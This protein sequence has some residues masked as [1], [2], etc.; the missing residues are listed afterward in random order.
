MG[1]AVKFT[2]AYLQTLSTQALFKLADQYGL[3]LSDDLARHLLIGELLELEDELMKDEGVP[4]VSPADIQQKN[5]VCSYNMTE[6]RA[7]LKDPL[8]FFVFWDFHKRL[9]TELTSSKGFDSFVLRVHSL[10]P[11]TAASLDFFDVQVPLV[12]R[13]RYVHVSF[14]ECLH[15]VELIARFSDGYDQHLAKSNTVKMLRKN[16]PQHLCVSQNAVNKVISLSGLQ[17]LKKSHFQHYRQAFR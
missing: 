11:H 12:D 3:C 5:T 16:I 15:Q 17:A 2:K 13:S 7:V 8:W 10:D 9:F 6:I 4:E 1:D 14:D